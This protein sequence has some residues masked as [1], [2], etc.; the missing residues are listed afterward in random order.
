MDDS[1][2]RACVIMEEAGDLDEDGQRY[3]TIKCNCRYSIQY[4]LYC[5]HIFAVFN[6]LQI[7]STEKFL[8]VGRRWT[9]AF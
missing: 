3:D 6:L 2:D 5:R 7:K 4:G 9:K 1:K 8:M